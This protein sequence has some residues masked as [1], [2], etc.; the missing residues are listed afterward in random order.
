MLNYNHKYL[1]LHPEINCTDKYLSG[2]KYK[3][4][5]EDNT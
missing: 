2:L 3:V 4:S 5:I 1:V